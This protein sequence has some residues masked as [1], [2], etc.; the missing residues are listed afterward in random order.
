MLSDRRLS[1]AHE[2]ME[3]LMVIKANDKIWTEAERKEILNLAVEKYLEKRRKVR[4]A[5]VGIDKEAASA[6]K[7]RP[8]EPEVTFLEDSSASSDS[9]CS[10]VDGEF[11]DGE[12]HET[13]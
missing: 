4:L 6:P 8:A 5:P 1:T 9:E 3:D 2:T 12:G 10:E 13:D 7:K 11:S